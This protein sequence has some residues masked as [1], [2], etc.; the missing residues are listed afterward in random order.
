[1]FCCFAFSGFFLCAFSLV[2]IVLVIRTKVKSKV[3]RTN[4]QANTNLLFTT[5]TNDFLVRETLSLSL[6]AFFLP[7]I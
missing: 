6:V 1:M 4:K 7:G 3:I 2:R 5:N